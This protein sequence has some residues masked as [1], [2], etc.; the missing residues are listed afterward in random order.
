VAAFSLIEIVFALGV[1]ATVAG[2]ASPQLQ[3]SLDDARAVGAARYVSAELQRARMNAVRRNASCALRFVESGGTYWFTE[4]VDG[5]RNGVLTRDIRS[6]VDVPIG[7]ATT[8]GAHFTGLEFGT[9]PGLPGVDVD[10]VAPGVDPIRLGAGNMAVFTP[11][12]TATGG[13]LYIRSAGNRQYAV[14]V[15]G[16]TGRTR[17]LKFDPRRFRWVSL[18][19]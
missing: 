9:L 1:A 5:T 13:T 12:G 2:A 17:V 10:S 16:E 3:A 14:R 7:I 18:G 15:F 4:F 11:D 6:G 19:P 8:L